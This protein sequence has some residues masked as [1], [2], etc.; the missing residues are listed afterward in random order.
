MKKQL[1]FFL[2]SCICWPAVLFSQNKVAILD[3]AGTNPGLVIDELRPKPPEMMGSF[4]LADQWQT[5][6]VYLDSKRNLK[7]YLLKFDLKNNVLEIKAGETIKVCPLT[8]LER[9]EWIDVSGDTLRFL[10]SEKLAA[11]QNAS[12]AGVLEVLEK[13]SM[14]LLASYQTEVRQPTYV[15]GIDVGRKEPR[16]DKKAVYYLLWNDRLCPLTASKARIE[17]CLGGQAEPLTTYAKQ[18]HLKLTRRADL[19]QLVRQFNKT[20]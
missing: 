18:N 9:F 8:R 12:V 2:L 6:N 15:T 10:N 4:Y 7:N 19:I 11:A 5:G 3:D 13:G 20:R 16:I 1:L 17:E 14:T